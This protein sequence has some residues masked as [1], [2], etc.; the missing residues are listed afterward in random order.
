MAKV[1]ITDLELILGEA[2]RF[3]EQYPQEVL[4]F[5]EIEQGDNPYVANAYMPMATRYDSFKIFDQNRSTLTNRDLHR[6]KLQD[7]EIAVRD[8]YMPGF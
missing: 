8:E 3:C 5:I 1:S 7:D 2:K 6:L 4:P